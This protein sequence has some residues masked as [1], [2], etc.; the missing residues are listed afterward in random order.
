[1]RITRERLLY[2]AE[3]LSIRYKNHHITAFCAQMAYFFVLSIFPLIIFIFTIISK[4]NINYSEAIY[5]LQQFLP[6]N[7]SVMITDFIEESIKMEGNALLSISGLMTLYSA[8]RAVN[9]LQ[10][11]LN[12]SLEI[13]EAHSFLIT[14]IYG[15]F[16]TLMFTILIVLSLV[17]PTISKRLILFIGHIFNFNV[18]LG[19]LGSIGIFRNLL[20]LGIYILVFGSIYMFLPSQKMSFKETYKGAIF[21]IAG[22]ILA[23]LVF[24]KVVTKLTDYSILYGS[25]SA[26]IAFM[27]WLYIWGII[28]I[29]GAEI[30]AILKENA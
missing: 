16:Y 9:A 24:S 21:A 3:Q 27:V 20:L 19:L 2:Y 30:N 5:V 29:M 22:T 26:V 7:I 28:I 13:V 25:L 18:D 6:T 4:L 23:N 8:S 11:A 14:K 1:M 12:S 17:I 10:R 15:M